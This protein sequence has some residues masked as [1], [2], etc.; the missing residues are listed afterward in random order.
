M[1]TTGR[2]IIAAVA[3]SVAAW[4]GTEMTSEIANEVRVA[5]L[6]AEED[7]ELDF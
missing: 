2:N 4:Y 5:Q 7:M 3:I 6:A 1:N